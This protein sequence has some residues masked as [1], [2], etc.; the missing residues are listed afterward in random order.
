MKISS[1]HIPL[2]IAVILGLI[3]T[4]YY[5]LSGKNSLDLS[6]RTLM[7]EYNVKN[8]SVKNGKE[9]F[10]ECE[11]G[12]KYNIIFQENQSSYEDLIFNACA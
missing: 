4:G 10:I 3:A 8:V 6:T 2:L 12:E 1:K 11:N 7:K 9:I 5:V